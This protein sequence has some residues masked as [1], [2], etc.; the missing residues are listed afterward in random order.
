MKQD[1]FMLR[2]SFNSRPIVIIVALL[3][4]ALIIIYISKRSNQ[5][6][7][8]NA[9]T[10]VSI[11]NNIND[12]LSHL[13][14]P[15]LKPNEKIIVHS[16]YAL[17]YNEKHEQ[18]N[19]VAYKL[20]GTAGSRSIQFARTD[21]FRKDPMI[22]TGSANDEDYEGSGY[23]RGHLAPAEDMSWSKT[24]MTESFYYTNMSPQ[25]P[26]F[27]RG[28]WKR[29]EE[30]VRFWSDEYDSIYVVTGPVLKDGLKTIGRDEVSVPE[31]Y[32]KAVLEYNPKGIKCIGFILPNKPSA[33]PLKT[34]AVPVDSIETL[35]GIDFFPKLP[36][37]VENRIESSVNIKDWQWTRKK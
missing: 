25:V 18:A 16:A 24:S 11:R 12:S 9:D 28:V 36:D 15:A 4:I 3:L 5:N 7:Y 6:E 21:N 26:S 23:D 22:A 30:L 17:T 37:E 19:W 34:F 13:E 14:I 33:A 2:K 31:Y 20:K 8:G 29:L 1:P 10:N 32:F 27:N 35:T